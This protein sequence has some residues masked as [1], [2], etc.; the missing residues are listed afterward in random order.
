MAVG[1]TNPGLKKKTLPYPMPMRKLNMP[2]EKKAARAIAA[3]LS[4]P[5]FQDHAIASRRPTR[6]A[7][8]SNA[9]L[10]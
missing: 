3:R 7:Q 8:R 1:R 6:F 2:Q 5:G 10:A 4:Q 9:E